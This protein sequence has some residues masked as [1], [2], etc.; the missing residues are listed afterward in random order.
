[1]KISQ[2]K[3]FGVIAAAASVA[4]AGCATPSGGV[5]QSAASPPVR[6]RPDR[7]IE[8]RATAFAGFIRQARGIDA[9]FSGPG[10]VSR[11]L[12]T[13][14][15]Y[16]PKE[17]EAGMIAYAAVAALQEPGFVAGVR[18]AGRGRG[19]AQ[20]MLAN[21]QAAT[22]LPGG[23]AAAARA[24]GALYRQGEALTGG[25]QGVKKAAY[26][27]QRQAWSKAKVPDAR[28]RLSRVKSISNAGYH[29][30]AGDQ[31]GLYRAVNEGGR[32]RGRASPVVARG[33]ALAA[34]S[35]LG[36]AGRGRALMSEPRSGLCLRMAKL[37]LYQCLAS[38]GPHY[39]D[40]YCLGQ[41][42]LMETANCVT[43][44]TR[45]PRA[46]VTKASYRR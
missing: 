43:D 30:A 5:R 36:E 28:G 37:N 18:K 16:D 44:A 3:G 13:G 41:H 31:A 11:A 24:S 4:L 29:V 12:Q 32:R 10:E 23:D 40:I 7:E 6:E 17:M 9:S 46:G 8:A 15:A 42:A 27:V 1:M 25:G 39:E 34:L 38:A 33:V 45:A 20:R 21:P 22:D 19:L 14:A 2:F 26:S 35:V